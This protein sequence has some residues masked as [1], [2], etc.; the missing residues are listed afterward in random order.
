MTEP[1]PEA[2]Q[3]WKEQFMACLTV[4][5]FADMRQQEAIALRDAN[6]PDS[7]FRYRPPG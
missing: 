3:N 4:P 1:Q 7:L 6:K 2:P 5:I